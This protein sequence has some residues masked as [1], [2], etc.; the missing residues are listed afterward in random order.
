MSAKNRSLQN[1]FIEGELGLVIDYKPGES[2][3]SEVLIGALEL[4]NSLDGLDRAL[5]SSIDTS[6]QPVSILNDVQHSSLKLLLARALKSIPDEEVK[7]LEWRKWVGRLLVTGKY[8]LLRIIDK[9]E[10]IESTLKELDYNGSPAGLL[11]YDPPKPSAIKSALENVS[12]ARS[13]L[14]SQNV[15]VQTELGDIELPDEHSKEPEKITES[16][17]REVETINTGVFIVKS[18]DLIGN[19]Q[20]SLLKDGKTL[21][22]RILDLDWVDSYHR[23]EFAILPGDALKSKYREKISYD[24]Q[25][26]EIER[27][28]EIIEVIEVISPPQN[29]RLMD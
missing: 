15:T 26:M 23:R 2:I 5:L 29:Q 8:K 12:R 7:N 19:A 6:L 4:I 3:A 24:E 9:P 11:G 13:I 21:K 20:W 10:L 22:S 16:L 25:N 27:H 28:I 14:G 17:I 18:P 1:E